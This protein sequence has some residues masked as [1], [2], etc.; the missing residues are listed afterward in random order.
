M[1]GHVSLT[2]LRVMS[3]IEACRTEALGGHVAAVR[4]LRP[5]HVAYN[6]CKNRHCPKCQVRRPTTGW[7]R[8]ARISCR[9]SI[10]TSSS[11]CRRRSPTSRTR[12]RPAVYGLLF[13]ASAETLRTIAADPRHLGARIGLTAVLHTWGSALT[14]HP[15]VH[16]V[17]PG[18]G[19]SPDGDALDR[20][21]PRV[22]S[23]RSRAVPTVPPPVPA[24]AAQGCM[25]PA[26]L[27]FFGDHG[28]STI[29]RPSR[30]CSHPLRRPSGWSTP[31]RPSAGPSPCSPIS[32]ATPT[33]WPSPTPG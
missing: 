10:S 15:H 29:P 26:N 19:L 28:R 24:R 8:A 20:V 3:A 5:R 23:A 9:W 1:P 21:S 6:S 2:Q 12:T 13:R 7:Q 33:A 30:A 32:A 31:S 18:G 4:G 27:H 22:L 14:H 11:P 25:A 16:C 17:V